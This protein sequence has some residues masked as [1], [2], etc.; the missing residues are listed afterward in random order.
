LKLLGRD[1][2]LAQ[3]LEEE[4]W[5]DFFTTVDWNRHGATVWVGPTL[6]AAGLAGLGEA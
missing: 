6:V 5:A 3:D 1:A 4:R 2:E